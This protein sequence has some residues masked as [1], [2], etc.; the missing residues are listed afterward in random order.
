ME[1]HRGGM[2]LSSQASNPNLEPKLPSRYLESGNG[3]KPKKQ[4][5]LNQPQQIS[6]KLVSV[7]NPMSKTAI[8]KSGDV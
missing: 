3:S 5:T 6:K 7:R 2:A 1:N 4:I 8:V